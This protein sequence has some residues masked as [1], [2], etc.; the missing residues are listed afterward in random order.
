M[1][2]KELPIL[3][4]DPFRRYPT[5]RSEQVFSDV[6]Q[7]CHACVSG[8]CCTNQ[9]AIALNSFDIFRL[10]TF[11]NMSPAEFMLNFT[12]DEFE[13]E[14]K[15][16]RREDWN[17]N[18]YNSVVT[19]LR[20]RENFA[21]SPCIFL[22]YVRDADGTAHRICS[23]HDGRPLSCREYYFSHCKTRGTGEL[24][25]LLAEGFEKVRDGKITEALVDSQLARFEGL[26]LSKSTIAESFEYSFWVEM[27]C[28]LNMD[29]ANI[30]G[31]KSYDMADYQDPIEKKLNRVISSK[32]LRFEERYGLEPRDE[33]LMPYTSGLS[34][35]GSAEY[36]RIM[37][38]VHTPPSL[39]LFRMR[40]FPY[41]TSIR[42]LMPGV[43]Y[44]RVF[45]AIPDK[46]RNSFLKKIPRILL[47]PNHES[48]EVRKITLRDVYAATLKALNHLIRF[49]G[50][51]VALDPILE[52]EPP[53]TIERQL[54]SMLAN[55]ETALNSYIARNPYLQPVK[56]H[57]AGISIQMLEEE[58]A[59]AS[60]EEVFDCFRSL[61]SLQRV[62]AALSSELQMRV[63]I[64]QK[65]ISAKLRKSKVRR[66]LN[67][68]NP[69]EARRQAGKSLGVQK[70]WQAWSEWYGQMLDMRY[71]NLA[72]FTDMQIARFYRQTIDD[73]EKIP[74][75]RDYGVNLLE[76]AK[77]LAY[78]MTGYNDI[79]YQAMQDKESADR[80]AIYGIHIFNRLAQRGE[81]LH[82]S[83][84]IAEFLTAIYKG[85]GLSY[86]HDRNFG[87]M[88]YRLLESQLPDGSWDTN[89]LP[90]DLPGSQGEFL[91]RMYRITCACVPGLVPLRHD[92]LNPENSA[93]RLL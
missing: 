51:I 85:L 32:Y 9:D 58:L 84:T 17:E 35:A 86:N 89:P 50:H 76:A 20:R 31:S 48:S 1:A 74:F 37:K 40:N 73:L 21:A 47:F 62:K 80:L 46:E 25:A 15:D 59:K 61:Q 65:A 75:R 6:R 92:I 64:I 54:L 81:N 82:D 78:S 8:A 45:P 36:E 34:F 72:D 2:K 63:E 23:V 69:I 90:E 30:E 52:H 44:A 70:A 4:F 39:G 49:S 60:A 66:Y 24:A 83:E 77:Y 22:K 28:V 33:Q 56:E 67:F 42:T 57:L 38:V 27:K 93:L 68:A 91:E 88:V 71:A 79:P 11:F 7:V 41:Y 13:G 43:R 18:P 3:T 29:Q 26:D 53:G 10:A 55:F 14:A 5:K 87:D 19:W 12:Q 16:L